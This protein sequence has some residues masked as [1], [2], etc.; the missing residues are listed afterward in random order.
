[1]TRRQF[2]TIMNRDGFDAAMSKLAEEKADYI[3]TYDT[4]KEF[5]KKL[6]DKEDNHYAIFLLQAVY[7]DDQHG[8]ATV[9][10][11][12]DSDWYYYDF[13]AGTTMKPVCLYGID[14]VTNFNL[15]N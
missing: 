4:L 13:T 8:K 7:D 9:F 10:D 3:H 2:R 14:D 12:A 6:I 5:I 1:M 15:F 11:Q